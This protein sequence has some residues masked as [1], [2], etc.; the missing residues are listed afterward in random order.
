MDINSPIVYILGVAVILTIVVGCAKSAALA[1][2]KNV[3]VAEA[4]ALLEV[5]GALLLD[6]RSPGEYEKMNIPGA[7]LIPISEL[8]QRL[9]ELDGYQEKPV[10]VHCHSGVR[11]R[12]GAR[13]LAKNG[14]AQVH[15]LKGGI[16]AWRSAE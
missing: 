14:F 1:G 6:V 10:V 15:N 7:K 16:V 11:S 12:K 2:Y 3:N 8:S 5:D 13:I 4:K 9:G